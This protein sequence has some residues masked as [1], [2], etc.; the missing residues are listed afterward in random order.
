[1]KQLSL[2]ISI[3]I[4]LIGFAKI[5][6]SQQDS[7]KTITDSLSLQDVLTIV[8]TKYPSIN[9]AKGAIELAETQIAI[10]K[11]GYLPNADISAS[12][13]RIG[14]VPSIDFPSI[15]QFELAP[16]NNMN[17]A[18]NVHET[19]WDFGTTSKK[20][21]Y[22]TKNKAVAEESLEL[23]KQNLSFAVINAYYG[24]VYIQEAL[25]INDEQIQNL[26]AHLDF[27]QKKVNTGSAIDFEILSTQVKLSNAE[28]QKT[29]LETAK[30]VQLA[31]LNSFL[32]NDA[33]TPI[34]LKN[35][36]DMNAPVIK[37]DSMLNTAYENRAEMKIGNMKLALADA[38]YSIVKSQNNPVL[39]F[40]ASAGFKNGYVPNLNEIKANYVVGLGLRIPVYDGNRKKYNLQQTN[41]LKQNTQY[42]LDLAKINITNQVITNNAQLTASL[43]KI[44]QSENQ[45]A[46]ASR[47]MKMAEVNFHQ[48]TITNMELIDATTNLSSSKLMLL[49]AKID[50]SVDIY[51][52]NLSMGVGIN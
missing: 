33:S 31:V 22:S 23:V 41:V 27:V 50:Y 40:M 20:V 30:E 49:K 51:K 14:P 16:A 37:V 38:Q 13:T 34:L 44:K 48:G 26:N 4:L 3:F 5:G 39:S 2:K 9:Q 43:K 21:D 35:D 11:T 36:V 12:Y 7:I 25:K 6:F 19:L 32:G 28:S 42:D 29:D 45:L 15:G 10:A 46:L 18:L 17:A 47:A 24:L 52:L 8:T 1:M